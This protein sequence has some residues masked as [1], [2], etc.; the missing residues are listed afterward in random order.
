MKTVHEVSA[1]GVPISPARDAV[2]IVRVVAPNGASRWVLPKGLVEDGEPMVETAVREVREETGYDAE[3]VDVAGDVEY[4]FVMHGVR[5]HKK[6]RYY[7]MWITG[8]DHSAHDEEDEEVALLAPQ[9]ALERL[10]FKN[11][12]AV[13]EKAID[14]ASRV[15]APR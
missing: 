8:G 15:E 10:S 2:A 11:E 4:W 7:A 6:V 1:G 13:L 14:I 9:T 3:P 5:H 12:R